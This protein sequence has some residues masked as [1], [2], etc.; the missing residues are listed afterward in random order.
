M[1]LLMNI[2]NTIKIN[3]KTSS[4]ESPTSQGSS[5]TKIQEDVFN[6]LFE[7]VFMKNKGNILKTEVN[8]SMNIIN[9]LPYYINNT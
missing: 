1:I 2:L 6:I 4:Q 8:K 9:S 7:N 5:K 3:T